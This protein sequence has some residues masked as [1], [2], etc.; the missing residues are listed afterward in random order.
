MYSGLAVEPPAYNREISMRALRVAI[1]KHL[2]M[3]AI[4]F[5]KLR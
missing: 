2:A 3:D 1:K 5:T 4:D